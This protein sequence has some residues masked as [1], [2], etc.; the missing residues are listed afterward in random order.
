ML[1]RFTVF[2]AVLLAMTT[3]AFAQSAR[4]GSLYERP[5]KDMGKSFA[6]TTIVWEG[7]G[8]KRET[9]IVYGVEERNGRIAVC[10][11][12]ISDGPVPRTALLNGL[13]LSS[14][15]SGGH[16]LVKDLSYFDE[17]S[18]DRDYFRF[19]CKVTGFK[20]APGF[21][22]TKPKYVQGAEFFDPQS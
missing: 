21:G 3:P 7:L 12:F 2:L 5:V 4:T 17:F 6:R 10:G 16:V 14:I 18:G 20:W 22:K 15:T 19:V 8:A 1:A 11:L 9:M 13:S